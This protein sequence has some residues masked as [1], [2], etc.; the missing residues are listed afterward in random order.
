MR[1]SP[2]QVRDIRKPI[3]EYDPQAS[4]LLF[5]SRT[6]DAAKG[7][8]IDVLCLSK[9]IDRHKRRRI[10]REISDRMDGQRVD[11]IVAADTSKPFVRLAMREAMPL[12][13]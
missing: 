7:G 3:L 1:L 11:L 9:K 13:F 4:I 5:G 2:R 8:D 10:R 6:D 12:N